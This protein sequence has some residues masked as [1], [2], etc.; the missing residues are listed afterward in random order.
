MIAPGAVNA[1]THLYSG[2]AGFDMPPP[3]EPP[4]DFLQILERIWWRLDRALDERSLRVSARWAL[5]EGLLAGTTAFIDHHESP[6]FVEGSLDVLAEEAEALGAR[7]VV[8]YGATERNGGREEARRGL[9]ECARFSRANAR[10]TVRP[11]VGLHA[12][13]TVSDATIREAGELARELGVGVHVHVAEDRADVEDARRR[14]F[15]GPLERLL[16]L[17]ALPATSIVAHG[18]WLDEAQVRAVESAG[19]WLVHN[20]RSNEG[21]RVGWA[22]SLG[23]SAHVALGTDGWSADMAVER[24]ALVRLGRAHGAEPARL[25]ARLDAGRALLGALTGERFDGLDAGGAADVVVGVPGEAPRH[26]IVAGR[27]VVIDGAL[28][29][30]DLEAIRAEARDTAPRLWARMAEI[31]G[32]S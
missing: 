9:A 22:G 23:A 25:E 8:A 11:L 32:G 24:A 30:A 2:L 12:S 27:P 1:H 16:A 3:A 19:A 26:V 21:N 31:G 13:F 17:D 7:L 28:V 10:P 14:G 4:Q 15:E 18:V 5:A 6:A 20:P 29:T